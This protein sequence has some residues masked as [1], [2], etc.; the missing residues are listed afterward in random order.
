M[1]EYFVF[2]H[3]RIQEEAVH[4]LLQWETRGWKFLAGSSKARRYA[5][6]NLF[7]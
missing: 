1:P 2:L 3:P 6:L 4:P 7:R 5:E